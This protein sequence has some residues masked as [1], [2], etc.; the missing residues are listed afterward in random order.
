MPGKGN[1]VKAQLKESSIKESVFTKMKRL[2]DKDEIKILENDQVKIDI[3][4]EAKTD[5]IKNLKTEKPVN[6]ISSTIIA[7]STKALRTIRTIKTAAKDPEVTE[8]LGEE[9]HEWPELQHDFPALE[10]LDLEMLRVGTKAR[11]KS[12]LKTRWLPNPC[13]SCL[14]DCCVPSPLRGVD[15]STKK[16]KL[17]L[18]EKVLRMIDSCEDSLV[19]SGIKESGEHVAVPTDETKPVETP[20]SNGSLR[21]AKSLRQPSMGQ[22]NPLTTIMPE[23]LNVV[24][25]NDWDEIEF[26]VDSGATETVMN[27]DML[28][29]IKVM[30]SWGSQN[31]VQY[32]V[33]N[34]VKIDNEGEKVFDGWTEEG[35]GRKVRA[36][37]CDVNKALMSVRKIVAAGNRVIFDEEGS[38]GS[39]IED[40]QTLERVKLED[41]NGMY[42]VK[43]WV[44]SD[45]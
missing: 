31:G 39:F 14:D 5:E 13:H 25:E 4:V 24:A 19:Q 12:R 42:M 1:T 38:G 32:E 27:C 7:P 45:F 17:K 11:R 18:D 41:R 8:D 23:G 20:W 28:S 40:K 9:V 15:D 33:A 37:V 2:Q 44:K 34:G 16:Y 35:L 30:P 21:L 10:S 22:L 36:Q 29:R 26:A 3:E 6:K 43:L